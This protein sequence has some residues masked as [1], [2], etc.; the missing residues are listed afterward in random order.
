M[1]RKSLYIAA[2]VLLL[3]QCDTLKSDCE[4][5]REREAAIARETPGDYF[6]GRRYRIPY[7]RFWGYLRRPGESWRYSKLVLMDERQCLTPDRGIEPPTEGAVFGRDN[8]VEY[9][10]K[11]SYTGTNAYDPSTNQVLPV[12]RPTAFEVRNAKPGYLFVP[13]EDYD[14]GYVTLRPSIMPTAQQCAQYR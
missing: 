8:N 12:F 4:A 7:T 9:I 3:C 13:S 1:I 2:A 5:L 14:P 6:I 11:G 10:I